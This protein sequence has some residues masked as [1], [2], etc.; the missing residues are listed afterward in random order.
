MPSWS[1]KIEARTFPADFRT[2]NFLG[3][4]Y[5]DCS[6]ST[7]RSD[8]T[9]FRPWSPIAPNRKSFGSRR[10]VPKVGQTTGNADL[11]WS[12]IR[13]FGIHFAESFRM[14]KSSRMMDPTHSREMPSCLAIY[15]AKIWQSSKISSWV[16]SIISGVVTVLGR[17]G[18]GASQ[19]EKSPC[20]NWATQF[21]TSAYVGA[22][23]RNVSVRMAW[24]SL[25]PCLA[26]KKT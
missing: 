18:Q 7:V 8:T 11:F 25:A 26:G 14:S 24:I 3:C 12:A 21:L 17:P 2:R 10:K 5:I 16:W 15:L 19:V 23:S 1:E 13:H 9:R 20:L 6:L 4:H 22:C